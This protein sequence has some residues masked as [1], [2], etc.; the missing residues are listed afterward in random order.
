M[1]AG[2]FLSRPQPFNKFIEGNVYSTLLQG[3]SNGY[4][5]RMIY[6][7]LAVNKVNKDLFHCKKINKLGDVHAMVLIKWYSF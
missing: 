1:L 6:R 7:T 4:T 3:D 5:R 2:V